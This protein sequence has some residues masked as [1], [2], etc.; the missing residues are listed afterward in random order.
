MKEKSDFFVTAPF[1]WQGEKLKNKR[2]D[3]LRNQNHNVSKCTR[4]HIVRG[5]WFLRT[6]INLFKIS[7]DY[8]TKSGSRN[9][10]LPNFARRQEREPLFDTLLVFCCTWSLMSVEFAIFARVVKISWWV[11]NLLDKEKSLEQRVNS[12]VSLKDQYVT[13]SG[14][15]RR[16]KHMQEWRVSYFETKFCFAFLSIILKAH[17]TGQGC[18]WTLKFH[19][20]KKTMYDQLLHL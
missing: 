1:L 3:I 20:L 2:E 7:C 9:T 13:R 4:K 10:S 12:E 11:C 15:R 19:Q 16:K 18:V 17:L 5:K 6:M 14:L 8:F